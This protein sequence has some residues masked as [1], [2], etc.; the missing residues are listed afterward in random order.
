MI[1]IADFFHPLGNEKYK[2]ILSQTELNQILI[3]KVLPIKPRLKSINVDVNNQEL[4][5]I[6]RR[7]SY[8]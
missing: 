8:F 5:P 4:L 7:E 3:D 1:E 2:A 6:G